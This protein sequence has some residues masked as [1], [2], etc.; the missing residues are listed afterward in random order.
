MSLFTSQA[1][2]WNLEGEL[3]EIERVLKPG[4]AAIHLFQDPNATVDNP[5]HN[6]LTSSPWN[7][8]F[9]TKQD[10]KGLKIKY[11]KTVE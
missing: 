4:G 8:S 10:P 2:G 1:I 3:V 9:T 5:I 11:H 6:V 7:Y